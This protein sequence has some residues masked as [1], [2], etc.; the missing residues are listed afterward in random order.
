LTNTVVADVNMD[1]NP[2]LIVSHFRGFLG[3]FLGNG[4]GTFQPVVLHDLGS[5]IGSTLVADVNGDG[6]PDFVVLSFCLAPHGCFGHDQATVLLGNGDGTFQSGVAYDTGAYG[7][8]SIATADING[9]GK[10]D[11]LIS[12]FCRF[13][14]TSS[15]ITTMLGNGDGTFRKAVFF[16]SGGK[17]GFSIAVTDV[18]ADSKPDIVMANACLK[19]GDCSASAVGILL[20]TSG[21]QTTTSLVSSLDQ[22]VYGK[23]VTLTTTITSVGRAMPTGMVGFQIGTVGLGMVAVSGGKAVLTKPHLPA[24]TWSITALQR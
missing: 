18:N 23:P 2:D 12:H 10:P 1:G 24:G 7:A 15:P 5:S 8:S 6:K 11:L 20:G 17:D 21:V 9:D 13:Y 16:G 14:C 3:V 22:S 19:T 4:D